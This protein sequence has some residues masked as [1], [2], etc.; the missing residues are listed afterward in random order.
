MHKI[1]NKLLNQTATIKPKKQ[2]IFLPQTGIILKSKS[3]KFI[4]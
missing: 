1:F 3:N 2:L 4:I